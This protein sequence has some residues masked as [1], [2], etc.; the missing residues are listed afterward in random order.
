[1]NKKIAG[2]DVLISKQADFLAASNQFNQSFLPKFQT[3]LSELA[4][5]RKKLGKS[6]GSSKN[7]AAHSSVGKSVISESND[8]SRVEQSSQQTSFVENHSVRFKNRDDRPILNGIDSLHISTPAFS[9]VPDRHDQHAKHTPVKSEIHHTTTIA[10]SSDQKP[11][12]ETPSLSKEPKSAGSRRTPQPPGPP[13]PVHPKPT[14][15]PPPELKE[16]EH[17]QE[18]TQHNQT[19]EKPIAEATA[20]QSP[21]PPP[22]KPLPPLHTPPVLP[23][24]TETPTKHI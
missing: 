14:L 19:A 23:R 1:L 17:K 5:I 24:T 10:A 3:V 15:L 8:F 18:P 9:S 12:V 4:L 21:P 13:R 11:I 2:Q 16:V 6:S 7:S 22:T 20:K